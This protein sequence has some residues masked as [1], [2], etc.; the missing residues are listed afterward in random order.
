M[1]EV[2]PTYPDEPEQMTPEQ[3][4]IFLKRFDK[5][6]TDVEW[7]RG[8]YQVLWPN[9]PR[10]PRMEP[11]KL[12]FTARHF[13]FTNG[14]GYD[15]L[16]RNPGAGQITH[17]PDRSNSTETAQP[18]IDMLDEYLLVTGR[19]EIVV[20]Q[21]FA[22]HQSHSKFDDPPSSSE[23]SP[24]VLS[25]SNSATTLGLSTITPSTLHTMAW[26]DAAPTKALKPT[27][28]AGPNSVSDKSSVH[29]ALL[30]YDTEEFGSDIDE[31]LDLP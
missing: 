10:G 22:I 21:S 31:F 5:G 12:H 9:D 18:M 16:Q 4:L 17:D 23:A 30:S 24:P 2:I 13:P 1:Q 14:A 8:W 20:E 19:D 29:Q 6:T 3:E 28:I 11:C 25:N 7:W 26:E 27:F 15:Y